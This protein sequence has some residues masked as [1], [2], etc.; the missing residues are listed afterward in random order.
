MESS[1][2]VDAVILTDL[3]LQ[4]HHRYFDHRG[5]ITDTLVVLDE[6]IGPVPAGGTLQQLLRALWEWAA[7]RAP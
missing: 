1:F 5:T 6:A 2:T 7:S 4:L 3:D